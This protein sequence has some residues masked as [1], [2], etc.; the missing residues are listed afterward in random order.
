MGANPLDVRITVPGPSRSIHRLK[1][2]HHRRDAE[3]AEVRGEEY[4]DAEWMKR[5]GGKG[6]AAPVKLELGQAR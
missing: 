5:Q 2:G 1:R 6:Q 4:A 3:T